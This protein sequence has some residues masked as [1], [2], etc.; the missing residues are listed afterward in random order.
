[1]S[2][3]TE[4]ELEDAFIRASLNYRRMYKRLTGFGASSSTK[5]REL[6]RAS[7]EQDAALEALAEAREKSD[8]QRIAGTG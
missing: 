7:M 1:M 5:N 4:R 8:A 2:A 6:T 3:P